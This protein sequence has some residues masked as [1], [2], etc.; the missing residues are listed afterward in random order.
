MLTKFNLERKPD[1]VID[2]T[3]DAV[4]NKSAM[5][6]VTWAD[7]SYYEEYDLRPYNPDPLFQK[8]GAYDLFDEMRQ[9]DQI[10]AVLNLQKTMVLDSGWVYGSHDS[11][12]RDTSR[13]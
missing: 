13:V 1:N 7:S 11:G 12:F 8:K 2:Y 10:A 5:S 3:Q 4:P 6:E 9:D